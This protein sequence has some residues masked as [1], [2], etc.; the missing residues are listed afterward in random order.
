MPVT[1]LNKK[2]VGTSPSTRTVP[3]V[4]TVSTGV[5]VSVA[6]EFAFTD[7][8]TTSNQKPV[9]TFSKASDVTSTTG[10]TAVDI[11]GKTEFDFT[12]DT[13]MIDQ[14]PVPFSGRR[15]RKNKVLKSPVRKIKVLKNVTTVP[16]SDLK[17]S[18][19]IEEAATVVENVTTVPPPESELPP[20][21]KVLQIVL[22]TLESIQARSPGFKAVTPETKLPPDNLVETVKS[23][24]V[25]ENI[26]TVPPSELKVLEAI[27][28]STTVVETVEGVEVASP[29]LKVV[30]QETKLPPHDLVDSGEAVSLERNLPPPDLVE[31]SELK[32]V[33]PETAS[34]PAQLVEA[35]EAVIFIEGFEAVALETKLPPT[36]CV[37]TVESVDSI[38]DIE[39][40]ALETKLP[41]PEF[42]DNDNFVNNIEDIKPPADLV[43]TIDSVDYSLSHALPDNDVSIEFSRVAAK[44]T[45]SIDPVLL[46]Y[47]FVG[48]TAVENAAA[49]LLFGEEII[50]VSEK[51]LL[52]IQRSNCHPKARYM[53]IRNR[54]IESLQPDNFVND[55]IVDF[56][57]A[58]IMRKEVQ[59]E[60]VVY[61][62]TT[63][64]YST[65]SSVS[66]VEQVLQWTEK[67]DVFSKRYIFVPVNE[68][69]H[70]S[71][72]NAEWNRKQNVNE[73]LFTP[74]TMGCFSP[75]G[76]FFFYC[77]Y[78]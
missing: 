41:P 78:F 56:W 53:T 14:K 61:P 55:V 71:L 27:K 52:M 30:T 51:R 60:S 74:I 10:T 12:D 28:E 39:T 16:P 23:L 69:L 62:M 45:P 58:W 66:G 44:Q 3:S 26:T 64:F 32:A 76:M 5:D 77:Y 46:V 20:G 43:E 35:V 59:S 57:S 34:T 40:V 75:K 22:E 17:V 38:D 72:L 1:T 63:Y 67:M 21:L 18:K 50:K 9:R 13:R 15:D 47:P 11:G 8:T 54:D 65:L 19:S 36:N 33:A 48:G 2:H 68:A 49:V 42:V 37:Q 4:R 7:D 29:E 70:W 6:T 24:Q 25:T 73:N 31:T